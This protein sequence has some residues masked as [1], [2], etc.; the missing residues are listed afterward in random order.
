MVGVVCN[1]LSLVKTEDVLGTYALVKLL[2]DELLCNELLCDGYCVDVLGTYALDKLLC[3]EL[4]MTVLI[5]LLCD[6]LRGT[7]GPH[8]I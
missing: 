1:E 2:S 8:E 3:D 4:D 7:L 5:E 6:L